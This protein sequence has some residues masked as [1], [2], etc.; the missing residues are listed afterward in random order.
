MLHSSQWTTSLK[1]LKDNGYGELPEELGQEALDIFF[2]MRQGKAESIQDYIFREEI[3]TVAFQKDAAIDLDEKIREYWLMGTSNLTERE[4][5][6][7]KIITQ[8]QTQLAQVKKAITQTIVAKKREE[9]RDD[10][11]EAG[12]RARDRPGG[13]AEAPNFRLHGNSD[14]DQADMISESESNCSEQWYELDGQEQE[15]LMSLRD[16]RKKLHHATKSRRFYAKRWRPCKEHRKI[17]RRVEES[18]VV[19]SMWCHRSLGRRLLTACQKPQEEIPSATGKG[20][21]CR[22]RREKSDGKGRGGSSNYAIV[23]VYNDG[24]TN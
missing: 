15:A 12:D 17:H 7:I 1:C 2:D 9:V 6:G 5:S 21:S 14:D 4:I 19:Q 23:E 8:G 22:L 13:Y 24:L 20:K 10:L 16:A 11:L 3:L 18:D